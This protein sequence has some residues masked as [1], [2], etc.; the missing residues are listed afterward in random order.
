MARDFKSVGETGS[1]RRFTTDT[2]E[3]PIGIK[4]PLELG[5]GH[6]GLFAMHTSLKDQIADNFRNLVLTNHGER[7][8]MYNFGANLR[9][10]TMERGTDEFEVECIVRIRDAASKFMPYID[11]QTFESKSTKDPHTGLYRTKIR[12]AY[13]VPTLGINK[14]VT[15]VTIF[16]AG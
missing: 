12:I 8:G 10:L 4:T 11:L 16:V 13:G 3:I 2:N 1:A 9:E 5:E 14:C 7:L 6:D 15:E